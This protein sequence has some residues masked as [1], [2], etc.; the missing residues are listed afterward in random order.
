MASNLF[1]SFDEALG[2]RRPSL[3][4]RI[5]AS[6]ADAVVRRDALRRR[7]RT[8]R[9]VRDLPPYLLKDIGLVRWDG[10]LWKRPDGP[11]MPGGPGR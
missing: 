1:T 3:L 10:R 4:A 2:D 5:M 11:T 6:V 9:L 7:A 8:E